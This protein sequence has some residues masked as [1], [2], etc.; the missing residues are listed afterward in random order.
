MTQTMILTNKD[1]IADATTNN[2]WDGDGVD[3]IF[4]KTRGMPSLS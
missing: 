2:N 1:I 4:D 3:T